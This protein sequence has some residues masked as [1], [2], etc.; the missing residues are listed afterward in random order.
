MFVIFNFMNSIF[1]FPSSTN[2]LRVEKNVS[3]CSPE[4]TRSFG[5]TFAN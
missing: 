2:I 4:E 1:Q 5:V 3:L